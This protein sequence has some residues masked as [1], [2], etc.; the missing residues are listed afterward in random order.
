[1]KKVTKAAKLTKKPDAVVEPHMGGTFITRKG[2]RR[3]H[4]KKRE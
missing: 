1:M 3:N 2:M 4:V